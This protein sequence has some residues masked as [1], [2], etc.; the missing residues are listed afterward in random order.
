MSNVVIQGNASGSG[1]ITIESPNTNSDFTI[2]LPENT[3]TIITSA[4]SVT[5]SQLPAGSVLQVVQ[6]VKTDTFSVAGAGT[7]SWSDVTGLSVAITPTSASS[8]I[9]VIATFTGASGSASGGGA[10]LVRD[11]TAIC[12]ATSTSNRTASTVQ[13]TYQVRG[14]AYNAFAVNF[15]DSP[16]TTSSVTYKIQVSQ[17]SG[18]TTYI[19][20]SITDTDSTGYARSTSQITVMEIA[21]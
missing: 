12:V 7:T 4:S 11:S 14:D 18:S 16:A 9:L 5:A 15:L 19:N 21:G 8:K 2:T 20:R 3:G 6:T 10:R 1:S 13:D 17:N